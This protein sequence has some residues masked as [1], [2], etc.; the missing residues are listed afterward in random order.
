M[1]RTFACYNCWL[2]FCLCDPSWAGDEILFSESYSKFVAM[3]KAV[4]GCF[5]ESLKSWCVDHVHGFIVTD[6]GEG[7]GVGSVKMLSH[8]LPH[9]SFSDLCQIRYESLSWSFLPIFL[10]YFWY[11][12]IV[13]FVLL[14]RLDFE[15]VTTAV[16]A[17][18][19]GTNENWSAF[20]LV[21]IFH[22]SNSVYRPVFRWWWHHLV[23]ESLL[24]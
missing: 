10:W 11:F 7:Q 23:P 6:S 19:L 15:S 4:Y 9:A 18:T 2:F 16:S 1:R 14:R 24:E 21:Q 20:I 22:P 17:T 3:S 8:I 12:C 5:W 13:W